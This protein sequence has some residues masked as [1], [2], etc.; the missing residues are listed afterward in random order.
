[1]ASGAVLLDGD[2]DGDSDVDGVDFGLW[3]ANYV[4]PSPA[5]Y[6]TPEPA[7]LGLLIVGGLLM[8]RRRR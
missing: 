5:V 8:L 6:H 4:A 2:A 3:Q 1:M 7:T